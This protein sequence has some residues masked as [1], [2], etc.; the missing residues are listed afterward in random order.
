MSTRPPDPDDPANQQCASRRTVQ[1][2]AM[3]AVDLHCQ[4]KRWQHETL[5]HLSTRDFEDVRMVARW[6]GE[7]EAP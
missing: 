4:L 5:Q 1:M 3:A 2:G 6:P 7:F